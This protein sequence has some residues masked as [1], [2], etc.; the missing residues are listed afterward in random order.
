MHEGQGL[1]TICH[2][3]SCLHVYHQGQGAM[4][5]NA[6]D[7]VSMEICHR[8]IDLYMKAHVPKIY[9]IFCILHVPYMEIL[10]CSCKYS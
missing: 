10:T 4:L 6:K 7:I 9:V 2:E 1:E 3:L 5:V 8:N